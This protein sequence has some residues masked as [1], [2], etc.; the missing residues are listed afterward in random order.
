MLTECTVFSEKT[1]NAQP[2]TSSSWKNVLE[3][4]LPLFGHRNW[5]VVTDMAYPLQTNPGITTLYADAPYEEVLAAV[6]ESLK[7]APHVYARVYQDEEL[8]YVSE[9]LCPGIDAFRQQTAEVLSGVK[10]NP[11]KHE[12]LI[13]KLD[14]I[15]NV[16]Q[17]LIIKTNLTK[18]YTSTFFELDCKYW[19]EQKQQIMT[20]SRPSVKN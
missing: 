3:D 7:K 5:V 17:V 16:F 15:S 9:E 11:Q 13:A 2:Q 19:D 18:P 12:E 14:A 4:K 10:V 1:Q 6:L 20:K 8:A